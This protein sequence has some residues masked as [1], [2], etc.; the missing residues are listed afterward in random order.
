MYIYIWI[1]IWTI[2]VYIY[3]YLVELDTDHR[4]LVELLPGFCFDVS[5]GWPSVP[6]C[7][8][9]GPFMYEKI[10]IKYHP[11]LFPW[12]FIYLYIFIYIYIFIFG[13][14]IPMWYF[15]HF[16][17]ECHGPWPWAMVIPHWESSDTMDTAAGGIPTPLKNDGVTASWDDL[18]PINDGNV[19]KNSMVPPTR[20]YT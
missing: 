17:P 12:S 16:F 8:T 5:V 20:I 11:V 18:F 1:I 15:S 6:S 3:I 4:N 9:L 19:I 13:I 10:P 2:C 7:S 14:H